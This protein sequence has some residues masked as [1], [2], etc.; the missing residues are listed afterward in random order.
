MANSLKYVEDDTSFSLILLETLI[1]TR[2]F[3]LEK[4]ITRT[5]LNTVFCKCDSFHIKKLIHFFPSKAGVS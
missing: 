4:E 5:L 2:I 3:S 1:P